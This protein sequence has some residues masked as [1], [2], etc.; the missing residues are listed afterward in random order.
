LAEGAGVRSSGGA[1]AP[2]ASCNRCHSGQGFVQYLKQLTGTL[3]TPTGTPIA[4]SYPGNLVDPATSP[5]AD[6]GVLY[7]QGLGITANK[8]QPVTCA[9]CHEPHGTG[10]RVEGETPMLPAGFK[11]SGA[12]AGAICFVCHNSRNGARSDALN[13]VYTNNGNPGTPVSVTSIGAPHEAAQGDVLAGRN[14]FF[15]GAF[16]PSAH[17]AVEDT[18]VGC[19]MRIFPTGLTGTN[20]NHTWKL[21]STSCAS[22]HGGVRAPV[23]GEAVQAQFHDAL[24]EVGAALDAVGQATVRNLFYKGSSRTVQVPADATAVFVTGRSPGFVL[25]FSTPI[26]NPN[27]ASGTVLTLGTT[28][29]PAGLGNF[30]TDPGVTLKAFDVLKGTFAKANWNY[31]LVAVDGSRGVHN[32]SFTFDVLSGTLSALYGGSPK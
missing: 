31:E 20:T 13:G 26:E 2:R 1:A 32:P 5:L 3:T 24:A 14:A 19:H 6:G 12:G 4:G 28:G 17:L 29:S 8:V 27:A 9:V 11:V 21:D 23:D 15:V 25:T 18:C 22:C 30:Y 16:N 10:L 7:L